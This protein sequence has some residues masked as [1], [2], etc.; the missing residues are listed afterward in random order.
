[1]GGYKFAEGSFWWSFTE[2]KIGPKPRNQVAAK[3]KRKEPN[4]AVT[5][6]RHMQNISLYT[7]N[8]FLLTGITTLEEAEENLMVW[9]CDNLSICQCIVA[10]YYNLPLVIIPTLSTY[11]GKCC[12]ASNSYTFL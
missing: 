4:R 3:L 2:S 5:S 1:M 8:D 12:S 11:E 6:V 10:S 7:V 9:E